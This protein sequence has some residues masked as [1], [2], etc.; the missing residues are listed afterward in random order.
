MREER[1]IVEGSYFKH[2]RAVIFNRLTA[3]LTFQHFY[4]I[5]VLQINSG[6]SYK[7]HMVSICHPCKHMQ[8]IYVYA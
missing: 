5:S 6:N 7:K 2:Y 8:H 1:L 3:Q 4:V